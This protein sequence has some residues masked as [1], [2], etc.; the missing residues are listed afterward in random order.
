MKK[1][2]EFASLITPFE[3]DMGE[4]PFSE[5]PRHALK[6]D[7]YICLNGKWSFKVLGK[8]GKIK[9]ETEILVPFP[10][11]S[12]ISGADYVTDISDVLV[13]ERDF[14]VP[15]D[16]KKDRVLLHFGAVDQIAQ[17][18]VNGEKVGEHAGGYLPF[19]FDITDVL[20]VAGE[21]NRLKVTV[22]DRM[23]RSYPYGKQRMKRGGMWYTPVSGI[24]QTV[25]LES[26]PSNYVSALKIDTD[27]EKCTVTVR[28]GEN[29]KR[30]RLRTEQGEKIYEFEG[31]SLTF[32]PDEI[33]LWTPE[34][35]YLYRFTLESGA[36]KVES[37]FALREIS[38]DR[39]EMFPR[40]LLNGKPY[41]FHGL[42]DQGYFSD[43]IYLPATPEGFK[44]DI[45][46]MKNLGFN[47]LRKHIKIE[48]QLFYYYCDLYGMA[49]FQDLVNSGGY[50]FLVDTALPTVFLRRG[51]THRASKKRKA[52]F[53][54]SAKETVELLYNH[55]SV[56]YYTIFNEGWGQY[57]ADRI[58]G[59]M[60]ALDGSRVWDTTSGW[61]KTKKSDVQS[62]H[63]YFKPINLTAREGRP[64]VLSEFGGF[65]YKVKDH[66]FNP[67]ETYGYRYY[68]T[69]EEYTA[70]LEKL[71][72]CEIVPNVKNGL[73]ATVFTQVS[74]VEDE[75]NG[76]LTYDRQI[77]KVK[78]EPMQNIAKE[79]FK[80]FEETQSK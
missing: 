69:E 9:K 64:L 37:Y 11:Q 7:S 8:K 70:A 51:V 60:K 54:S 46:Q 31:E 53:E 59:D 17:V 50:S 80:A 62:E 48:P 22:C 3:A 42:L 27:T 57:E 4:I 39:G 66:S 67:V 38:A 52:I 6:R 21:I 15:Q 55:P 43:G 71:Y 65:S 12:R 2:I 23:D 24:W 35:P 26:V 14:T 63:I 1:K 28:G 36:D 5:Y 34:T 56:V 16:F 41:F 32:S 30:L 73:C 61:F 74:D 10:P 78:E 18:F 33:H 25:W 40:L 76:L 13:Y 75:T 45:L 79:I 49:V 29:K 20:S 68:E 77:L 72:L 58:Y 19:N 47:M 44:N